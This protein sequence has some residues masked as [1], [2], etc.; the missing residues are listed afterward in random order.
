MPVFSANAGSV[1]YM[2]CSKKKK[3]QEVLEVGVVDD[4]NEWVQTFTR[5]L[6]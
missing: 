1:H 3:S 5:S 4:S 2:Y 6:D